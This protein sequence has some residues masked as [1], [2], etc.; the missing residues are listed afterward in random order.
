MTTTLITGANRGIGLEL[1]RQL[2][3]AGHDVIAV[4]RSSSDEL[5][6]LGV[7]VEAGIEL[8]D[9]EGLAE[10][11]ERL[12]QTRLDVL[13]NN[14]GVLRSSSLAGIEDELDDFRLQ[15]EVNALGPL[16]VT[17][18]LLDHLNEG[19]KV[20]II[21]SRMGSIADNTSGGQYA[22]RMSKAAVNTAGVSLAHEL[23]DRGIAVG[24]L[25]PGYVRTGMT[26]NTGHIEAAE[27][28]SN[29]IE[30]IDEINLATSGSFRHAN[31]E[32]LPW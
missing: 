18:A 31:G 12:G 10:M 13:I 32:I 22:Y 2:N 29:L 20:I 27:A 30:R 5:D 15:Y 4:C 26:G 23:K 19:A 3:Q 8:T 6:A 21:T 24:L 1:A 14:A 9:R 28:A 16:R 17:R 7:R 25:H 11:A